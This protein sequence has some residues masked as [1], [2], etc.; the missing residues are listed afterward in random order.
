[1]RSF[2]IVAF[3]TALGIPADYL[4]PGASIK[5]RH[6]QRQTQTQTKTKTNKNTNKQTQTN[7]QTNKQ[8]HKQTN[9]FLASIEEHLMW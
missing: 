9:T 6:K 2:Q 7:K 4:E 1:M 3:F 5:N 8:T